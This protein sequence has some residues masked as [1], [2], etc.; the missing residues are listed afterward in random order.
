M[1]LPRNVRIIRAQFDVAAFVSVLFLLVLFVILHSNFVFTPGMPIQLPEAGGL[2]GTTNQTV[3]VAVDGQG[4]FYFENQLASEST[5]KNR[6][7]GVVAQAQ[8]PITLV[9]QADRSVTYD[10]LMRLGLLARE[11]GLREA[12]LAVRPHPVPFA[13]RVGP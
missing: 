13:A 7:A 12:L 11:A 6:L 9:I 1:R 8:E 4:Q 3:T 2:S 5:L 10:V